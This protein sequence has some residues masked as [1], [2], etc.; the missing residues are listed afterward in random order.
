[1]LSNDTKRF[2]AVLL[3]FSTLIGATGQLF[4]KIGLIHDS[5]EIKFIG[6]ITLGIAAYALSTVIYLYI[7]SRMHLSWT[8]G[9]SG[10]SYI[11]ATIFAAVFLHEYISSTRALGVIC[12]SIGIAAIGL[13]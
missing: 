3:I 10:L 2:F 8:Y 4:F 11:F 5:S 1:M 6:Y 7:L 9:F 12:I 13:S